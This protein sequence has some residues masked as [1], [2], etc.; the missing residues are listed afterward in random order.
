MPIKT[1]FLHAPTLHQIETG[2][3]P[4]HSKARDKAR[5]VAIVIEHTLDTPVFN[6]NFG[7][8][9][10]TDCICGR[11]IKRRDGSFTKPAGI[12]CPNV[13]CRT[14]WDVV[15]EAGTSVSFQRR[16]QEYICPGCNHKNYVDSQRLKPGLIIK[17]ECGARAEV[18]LGIYAV[19]DPTPVSS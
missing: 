9:Y 12:V 14:I 5:E 10:E 8:F 16:R 3:V 18:A 13:E 17:C 2:N 1:N 15:A 4:D 11:L 7:N 19:E 6:V